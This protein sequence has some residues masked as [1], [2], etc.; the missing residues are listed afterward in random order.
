MLP[1]LP[2]LR[3]LL[4]MEPSRVH[5]D[6]SKGLASPSAAPAPAAPAPR[7]P[8]RC[9]MCPGLSWVGAGDGLWRSLK[10]EPR[11]HKLLHFLEGCV[12][13]LVPHFSLGGGGVPWGGHF[14]AH[15]AV[16]K[17]EALQTACWAPPASTWESCVGQV[18]HR[19]WVSVGCLEV[20]ESVGSSPAGSLVPH[21]SVDT[22]IC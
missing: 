5:V 12:Q 11:A 13:G 8:S 14:S 20:L 6:T 4:C 7:V 19:A 17:H 9:N 1:F 2:S 22:V 3:L 18:S 10:P 21:P 16:P 15:V